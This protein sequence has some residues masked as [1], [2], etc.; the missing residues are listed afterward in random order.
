MID[1]IEKFKNGIKSIE[2]ALLKGNYRACKSYSSDM[3][4][5][6]DIADFPEGVFIGEFLES[7]FT[8]LDGLENR[9]ELDP[10]VKEEMNEGIIPTLT[11]LQELIPAQDLDSKSKI[12]EQLIV[13]RYLVTKFQLKYWRE[14][15][16]KESH[17]AFFER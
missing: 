5:A 15:S 16:P 10:S 2:D 1:F 17:P 13:S 6:S 12:Y 9:Y 7:L 14:S 11:S 8:N 4:R 3:L